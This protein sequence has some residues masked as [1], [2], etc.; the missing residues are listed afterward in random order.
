MTLET[1]LQAILVQMG[2]KVDT[3]AA[4]YAQDET[5]R[6]LADAEVADT[7]RKYTRWLSAYNRIAETLDQ[8][9]RQSVVP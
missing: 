9:T 2:Q 3:L 7:A 5:A 8:P 4:K 1:D 6:E